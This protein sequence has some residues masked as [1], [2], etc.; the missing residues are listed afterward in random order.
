MEGHP[1]GLAMQDRATRCK[2]KAPLQRRFDAADR[3][4]DQHVYEP[5]AP[6]GDEMAMVE[7]ATA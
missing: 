2:E 1:D 4:I 5:S 6:P 7:E 3:A